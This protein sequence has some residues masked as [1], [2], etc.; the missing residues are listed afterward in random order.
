M[1]RLAIITISTR[2]RWKYIDLIECMF[3]SR[4][5]ETGSPL[6]FM[7]SPP[8]P[9]YSSLLALFLTHQTYQWLQRRHWQFETA[10]R[11]RPSQHQCQYRCQFKEMHWINLNEMRLNKQLHSIF[12]FWFN[13]LHYICQFVYSPRQKKISNTMRRG[14]IMS[15]SPAIH[16]DILAIIRWIR[17]N[18]VGFNLL[19][20]RV[21]YVAS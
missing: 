16:E 19:A 20:M 15:V 14:V 1:S 11:R 18:V 17:F 9:G 10:N 2:I 6:D 4:Y 5:C 8:L 12:Q 3:N 13:N 7:D 21:N